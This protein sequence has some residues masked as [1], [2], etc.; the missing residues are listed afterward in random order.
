[1][2]LESAVCGRLGWARLC[3]L[4][5]VRLER[6]RGGKISDF[7]LPGEED[8]SR[9]WNFSLSREALAGLEAGRSVL[10]ISC[11]QERRSPGWRQ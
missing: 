9:T 5:A 1:M 10:G 4:S 7:S 6:R 2:S 8:H 3:K 11:F